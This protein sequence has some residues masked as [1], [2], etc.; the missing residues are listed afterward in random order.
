[1]G[2]IDTIL[3]VRSISESQAK[4]ILALLFTLKITLFSFLV[5]KVD[6]LMVQYLKGDAAT[7]LQQRH[8]QVR[9]EHP[10][11]LVGVL[12]FGS[13]RSLAGTTLNAPTVARTRTSSPDNRYSLLFARTRSLDDPRGRSRS[14]LA[15]RSSTIASMT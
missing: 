14:R 7:G 8:A 12:G 6:L 13:R 11:G 3:L 15:A 10:A 1:M 4:V 5:L 9:L 2:G